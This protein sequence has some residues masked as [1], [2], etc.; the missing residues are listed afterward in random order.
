MYGGTVHVLK[1]VWSNF[2]P[3]LKGIKRIAYKD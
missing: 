2:I 3:W 1:E